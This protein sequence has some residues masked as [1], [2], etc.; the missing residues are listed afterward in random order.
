MR[1]AILGDVHGNLAALERVV[2]DAAAQGASA[3][4]CIGDIVGYNPDPGRCVDT[5]RELNCV[6]IRGNH[7]HYCIR[8]F[9]SREM[10]EAAKAALEWT[11]RNVDDDQLC[12]LRDLP[13]TAE[14]G[15]FSIVH[16]TLRRTEDWNYVFDTFDAAAHFEQQSTQVC[17]HGHTHVPLAF[18]KHGAV[19]LR[20]F[21]TL[22]IAPGTRYFINVG[23]VGQPRDRDPRA[24]YVVY[25]SESREV[26]LRRVAYDV[27]ATQSKIMEA[28]LPN[29]LAV[30]L[31][32]GI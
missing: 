18:T 24:A 26:T 3:Y 27:A 10:N 21:D 23:S 2:D 9:G 30:R 32:M 6:C 17:F 7:D 1:Y 28:G 13:M 11:R 15:D 29:W 20:L 12:F 8:A 5:L 31:S 22:S 19:K 14:V 4:V 25:D 16:N